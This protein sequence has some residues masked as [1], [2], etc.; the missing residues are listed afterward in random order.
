MHL[1]LG[2]AVAATVVDHITAHKGDIDNFL[3]A[4]NLQSL[5]KHCHD[6]HK[7]AQ[8]NDANGVLRGAGLTGR[9]LDL[10]HPWHRTPAPAADPGQGGGGK[11]STPA[12]PRT[13]RFPPFAEPRNG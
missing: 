7:Q 3:A 9:P 13:G 8:E 1:E 11:K 10:A 6:A 5:C 4:G 12:N 2:N